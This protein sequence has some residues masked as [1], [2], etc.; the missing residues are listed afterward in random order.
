MHNFFY[1]H[2]KRLNPQ[3]QRKKRT[4]LKATV[5]KYFSTIQARTWGFLVFSYDAQIIFYEK[6]NSYKKQNDEIIPSLIFYSVS[7]YSSK[8]TSLSLSLFQII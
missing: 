6:K 4:E 7:P 2:Y 8:I 5:L 1:K 3:Y